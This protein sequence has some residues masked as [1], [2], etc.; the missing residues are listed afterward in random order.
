MAEL[1]LAAVREENVRLR[2]AVGKLQG[3]VNGLLGQDRRGAME[4][5][6]IAAA[7]H[8]ST[9]DGWRDDDQYVKEVIEIGRRTARLYIEELT[10]EAEEA[11]DA[12]EGELPVERGE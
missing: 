5:A 2:A 11:P 7:L 4:V 1:N 6:F 8:A 3:M 10:A 12:A 9:E